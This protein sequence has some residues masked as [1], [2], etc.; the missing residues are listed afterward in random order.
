MTKIDVDIKNNYRI[1][2]GNTLPIHGKV[3]YSMIC[4]NG[5]GEIYGSADGRNVKVVSGFSCEVVGTE[6]PPND[7]ASQPYVPAKWI[8]AAKGDI[9][10]EAPSGTLYLNARNVV[11]NA[12]G[13]ETENESNGNIDMIATNDINITTSDT[14]KV[15][16]TNITMSA[17]LAM[18]LA[19]KNFFNLAGGFSSGGSTVDLSRGI[20]GS[21]GKILKSLTGIG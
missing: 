5:D 11:I 20:L 12:S 9:M 18:D 19:G 4:Q 10:I 13:S 15:A 1:D 8:R 7:D 16:A 21:T 3:N 6:L 14:V 2:G 17:S